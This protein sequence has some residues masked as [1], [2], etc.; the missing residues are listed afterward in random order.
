MFR[1]VV[2]W[3]KSFFCCC[4]PNR[5]H[6]NKNPK[7]TLL[8]DDDEPSQHPHSNIERPIRTGQVVVLLQQ[9]AAAPK[10]PAKLSPLESA[11]II[12]HAQLGENEYIDSLAAEKQK[13]AVNLINIFLKHH[14]RSIDLNI[15]D[16][17]TSDHY[18]C[19]IEHAWSRIKFDFSCREQSEF[20]LI[21]ACQAFNRKHSSFG[22]ITDNIIHLFNTCKNIVSLRIL[23]AAT[24]RNKIPPNPN[25]EEI[26]RSIMDE[27]IYNRRTLMLVNDFNRRADEYADNLPRNPRKRFG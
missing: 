10:L 24:R 21:P 5:R 9:P 19:R 2:N 25:K 22:A 17:P 6:K 20:S 15:S 7:Y 18:T 4:L 16:L 1:A 11:L 26:K 3:L 14:I 13:L 12:H 23:R 8:V 27:P